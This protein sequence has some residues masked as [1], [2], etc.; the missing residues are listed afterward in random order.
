MGDHDGVVWMKDVHTGHIL[1]E[2]DEHNGD[3][4]WSV[5]HSYLHPGVLAS[6]S[7]MGCINVWDVS[8]GTEQSICKIMAPTKAPVCSINFSKFSPNL[9]AMASADT[10]VYIY[11]M[12]K[13]ST[14]FLVL[15]GHSRTVSFV[16]FQSIS[17]IVSSSVDGTVVLWDGLQSGSPFALRTFRSHKNDKNFVG[18]STSD[19]GL[20]ACGCET[21][22]A[23]VYFPTWDKPLTSTL[24]CGAGGFVTSVAWVPTDNLGRS[25]AQT[26][27]ILAVA[28]T[29]GSLKLHALIRWPGFQ[30]N[31]KSCDA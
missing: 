20:I 13:A 17:R 7:G 11:D 21:G 15:S 10:N 28:D 19:A 27:Q 14:P 3:K 29:T 8:S 26:P 30:L 23:F 1:H 2:I 31:Q 16:S 6:S 22:S 5:S 24:P 12:R 25:P 9:L 4:V 18:L